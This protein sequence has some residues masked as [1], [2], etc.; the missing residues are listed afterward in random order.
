MILIKNKNRKKE[1]EKV[2]E[3][4]EIYRKYDEFNIRQKNTT[5]CQQI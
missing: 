4:D 1:E 3:K 2:A 5:I